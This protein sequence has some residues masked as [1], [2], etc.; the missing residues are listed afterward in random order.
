MKLYLEI[1][2]FPI[3]FNGDSI[4]PIFVAIGLRQGDSLSPF[5]FNICTMGLSFLL[6]KLER[7]GELHG[8]NVCRGAPTL[9]HLLFVDDCF[10]FCRTDEKEHIALKS[11]LD[12]YGEN[13][14]QAIN[15]KKSK[16]FF[17]Y[18]TSFSI[19]RKVSSY[20]GVSQSIG[21]GKYLGLPYII[22]RKKKVVFG[23]L[24]DKRWKQINHCSGKH[25]IKAG[26]EII[27]NSCAQ[28]IPTYCMTVF[29]LPSTLKDNLQKMMK[30]L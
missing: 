23:F 24:K 3:I 19:R 11:I 15:C 22:G 18:N 26:K 25:L 20:M 1:V 27:L 10:L 7:S 21:S 9:L 16:F 4:G 8:I 12:S 28:A 14:G 5:L 29:L 30:S 6:R 13:F 2:E 17:S